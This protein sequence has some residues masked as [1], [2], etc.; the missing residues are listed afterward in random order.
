MSELMLKNEFDQV[1][2]DALKTGLAQ[3]PQAELP[4]THQ[5]A[6]GMYMRSVFRKAGTVIV[7]HKCKHEHFY[8][9][10]SG[11][12]RVGK[13]HYPRGSV[14]VVEPG[15]QKAVYAIEDS[16]C[17]TIHRLEDPAERDIEKIKVQTVEP[18]AMALYD[19]SNN[20]LQIGV[21]T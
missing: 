11:L 20:A 7:G 9:V 19:A 21:M 15:T 12:V 1:A 6:D 5:F 3:L 16:L 8:I 13:R 2:L 17:A 14:V 18:D 4:T 10:L